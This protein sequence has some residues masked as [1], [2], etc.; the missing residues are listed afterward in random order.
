MTLTRCPLCDLL[1]PLDIRSDVRITSY[2]VNVYHWDYAHVNLSECS[3]NVTYLINTFAPIT[4][5]ERAEDALFRRMLAW[6]G[7]RA[8]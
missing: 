8:W 6:L 1:L 3:R 2:C 5:K 4:A 7:S